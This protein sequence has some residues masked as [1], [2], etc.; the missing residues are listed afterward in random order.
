MGCSKCS[1]K[2]EVN[3]N[4]IL[5]Q[6]IRKTLNRQPNFTRKTTGKRGK[7]KPQNQQKERNHKD[8]SRNKWEKKKETIIKINKTKSWFFDKISKIDKPLAKLIKKKRR[9]KST[10]LEMGR[11]QQTMQKQKV[12]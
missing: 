2:R 4:T 11:L 6:E 9:I 12:L 8:P 7:K 10:K 3:S 5:Q 1:S